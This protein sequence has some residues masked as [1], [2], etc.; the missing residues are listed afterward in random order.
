MSSLGSALLA[1]AFLAAIAA[2]ALAL[3]GRNGDRRCVDL[4][5]RAVYA[6]CGL[7]HRLRRDHRDR[8]RRQR[9]LLQH[10]R[11]ALLDRDAGLLQAGGDVVEPGG[12]AAALGLGALDRLQRRPLRDPGQAARARP[13]GDRGDDGRRRLLHRPDAV[14]ARR[15]PL[16]RQPRPDAGRRHRPQ[17]AAAAPEHD[18]P[19]ADALLGLRLAHRA[20]RLR[21]RRPRHPPPRRRMDPLHPPLRP[22]RLG[23]PRLRP[24]ARRPLVLHRARLGR[25]LGLG[26]GRERGA[27]AV[28]DRSPPSCTRSW[29]RRSGGC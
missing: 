24:P 9:L 12:L 16:R 23:L 19:P 11:R 25:L 18:D 2:A 17:P 27:D 15:Q 1:L 13:L 21:D 6:F 29:S 26:P 8:L 20:L 7:A 4:S 22:D 5:R 10:R 28:A 3:A 14:R